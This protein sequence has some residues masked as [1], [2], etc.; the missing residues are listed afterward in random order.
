MQKIIILTGPTAVGK[1]NL[2]IRLAKEIGGEIISAD[3]MQVY[4]GMDIGTAKVTVKE[5]DGIKHHLI[6]ILDPLE[7][8]SVADF[9]KYATNS[10]QDIASRGSIP[11]IVGGTGFY[12]Q[13]LYK[14]IDFVETIEN[15]ELVENLEKYVHAYGPIALHNRLKDI[16][17]LSAD[18]IHPNN[19]KRVIR[20]IEYY[21]TT[22]QKMSDHNLHQSQN[23]PVYDML[24]YVLTMDRSKLY[25]R[26]NFR[27]EQMLEQGLILEVTS[28]QA[29][30]LS[31]EHQSMQGIGY[32]ECLQYLDGDCSYEEMIA[33]IKQNSRHYAKRQLTW[34]RRE[35]YKEFV[36]KEDFQED[37]NL[38]L[39]K[40]LKDWKRKNN[41]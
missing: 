27:V 15:L 41:D 23:E 5:Q 31:K 14:N 18:A 11:I 34:F 24:Y 26:I 20:A 37:D 12:I 2:S 6:D 4:K 39:Q 21:E 36:V 1:T 40:I 29:K 10:I 35:P 25:E 28:L 30:G 9:T 32:K 3:S 22:Q 19:V 33:L 17:P 13:A 38:I 16:D 7:S 8:F